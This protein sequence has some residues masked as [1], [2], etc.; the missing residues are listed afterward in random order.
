MDLI[1]N[2]MISSKRERTPEDHFE[3]EPLS[4]RK[5]DKERTSPS[6]KYITFNE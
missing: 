6:K 1:K 2:G 3:G 5:I 4:L